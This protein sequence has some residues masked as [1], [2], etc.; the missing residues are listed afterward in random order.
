MLNDNG[1]AVD[2]AKEQKLNY[3]DDIT[4][5]L[6]QARKRRF[7]LREEQRIAEDI[8]LQTYLN[9]LLAEDAERKLT[10]LNDQEVIKDGDNKSGTDASSSDL[11]SRREEIEEKRDICTARL[12]DLFAKVDDRRRVSLWRIIIFHIHFYVLVQA[13]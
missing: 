11:A 7:Q 6:R 8:E 5:V 3:G 12:N 10:A 2:L 1:I 13:R 4:S 9:Q